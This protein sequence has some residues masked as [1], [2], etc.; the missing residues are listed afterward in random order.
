MK[1][2][3]MKILSFLLSVSLFLTINITVSKLTAAA[4]VFQ[5]STYFGGTDDESQEDANDLGKMS[6][7]VDKDGNIIVV[8]RTHS[9]DYPETL[10]I[11]TPVPGD[12]NVFF[13][14]FSPDGSTLLFSTVIPR[15]GKDWATDVDS[16]SEG[17]FYVCGV[18][19][20]SSFYINH[21]E[22]PTKNIGGARGY[23]AWVAKITPA[24]VIEWCRFF[25]G[26]QD[27]WC[28]SV[29]VDSNQNVY[30][31]GSTYSNDMA[32]LKPGDSVQGQ[33]DCYLA[34]FNSTGHSQFS[35]LIGS[36]NHDW[37]MDIEIDSEDNVVMAAGTMSADFPLVN[38]QNDLIQGMDGVVMK[39]DSDGEVV[40]S[41]IV[42]GTG[43]DWILELALDDSDDIY[44]TGR[45]IEKSLQESQQVNNDY[46]EF[47]SAFY[48]DVYAGKLTSDG[49]KLKYMTVFGGER[50][51]FGMGIDVDSDGNAYIVGE[52]NSEEFNSRE[53]FGQYSGG[54]EAFLTVLNPKG[55]ILTSSIFGGSQDEICRDVKISSSGDVILYGF[56][57]SSDFPITN[58][59]AG[60]STL[61]GG[62]DLFI[63]S[64]SVNLPSLPQYPKS[65]IL[66]TSIS[67]SVGFLAIIGLVVV[68]VVRKKRKTTQ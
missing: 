33:V 59:H 17:N 40:F 34:K 44:F 51:D 26:S 63:A 4:G 38:P 52:T 15:S 41:T 30:I 10:S 67:G 9:T 23:D 6:V 13:S 5:F 11:P 49:Q 39:F 31:T 64:L 55:R 14:K 65:F 66:W 56:T 42:G 43:E 24:G 25:G 8:G 32:L 58:S 3:I 18:T 7:E 48:E 46:S 68:L 29:G 16:D 19:A 22:Q 61:N 35:R 62:T 54:R 36:T 47:E 45:G 60:N 21:F 37:G 20:S 12:T 27:D 28:Y 1:R 2:K 50:N 57:E 53:P